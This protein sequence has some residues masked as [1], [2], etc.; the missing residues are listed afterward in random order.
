MRIERKDF[1]RDGDHE[2]D[3]SWS[4]QT[5]LDRVLLRILTGVVVLVA[6]ALG[7][8]HWVPGA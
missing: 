3:K 2:R 5:D 6:A 4:V 7:L 8:V 1:T